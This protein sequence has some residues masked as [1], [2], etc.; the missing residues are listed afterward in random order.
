MEDDDDDDDQMDDDKD[1]PRKEEKPEQTDEPVVRKKKTAKE[2]RDIKRAKEAALREIQ[3]KEAALASNEHGP[4]SAEDFER[5]LLAEPNSSAVWIRYMAF[6]LSLVQLD[7]ARALAERA[8]ETIEMEKELERVNVWMAYINLEANSA[9]TGEGNATLKAAAVFRVFDRAVKRVTD[10][11]DF[12]LQVASSL[13]E[14]NSE[15]SAEI[16]KRALKNFKYEKEVWIAAGAAKFESGDAP[17]GRKLLERALISLEKRDHVAVIMKFSQ[18]EYKY[19]SVEKGRTV[20]ESLIGNYPKRLD[21]WNVFLDMETSVCRS[22]KEDSQ[23]RTDAVEATRLIFERC[24]CLDLSSKKAKSVYKKWLGFENTFGDEEG[25][26]SV[27]ARAKQY[28]ESKQSNAG[29]TADG[30]M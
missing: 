2:K 14:S 6:R 9:S 1:E 24:S 23:E 4:E 8:L 25:Y 5:L 21:V 7:Q 17:A 13:R 29:E 28:V 19:G 3:Q 22:A 27:L 26:N 10:Q 18:L 11:L 15:I 20:F 16:M 12:Y 30:E